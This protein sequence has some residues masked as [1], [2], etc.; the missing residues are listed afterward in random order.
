MK[1]ELVYRK[2]YVRGGYR[3]YK[4]SEPIY[5]G[6]SDL[7]GDVDIK[8]V[9]KEWL[10]ARRWNKPEFKDAIQQI[11]ENGL[12]YVAISDAH[13]H[14]ERLVF[15]ALN[16]TFGDRS[17]PFISDDIGGEHTMLLEGGDP[18]SIHPD[19]VYLRRLAQLNK[20]KWEGVE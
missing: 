14:I 4:L 20:L 8:A 3:A 19:A 5:K 15:P 12:Y 6:F 16:V 1:A 9:A 11:A 2:D 17:Y 7:V 18:D 10:E 13:T